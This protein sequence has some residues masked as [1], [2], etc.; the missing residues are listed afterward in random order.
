MPR[1]PCSGCFLATLSTHMTRR[2]NRCYDTWYLALQE[3]GNY[4]FRVSYIPTSREI[5]KSINLLE[6]AAFLKTHDRGQSTLGLILSVSIM[7]HAR[8]YQSEGDYTFAGSTSVCDTHMLS[9]KATISHD[10]THRVNLCIH[11]IRR[12]RAHILHIQHNILFRMYTYSNLTT[13][14][15]F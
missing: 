9:F 3:A 12:S 6:L 8:A 2:N 14:A 1:R 7:R 15:L 10:L 5:E 13:C 11:A 4:L